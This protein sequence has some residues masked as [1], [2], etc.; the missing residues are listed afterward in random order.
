MQELGIYDDEN[1][2]PPPKEFWHD[3]KRVEAWIDDKK[4][5]RRKKYDTQR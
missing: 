3:T 1:G 2:D 5:Q 4:E